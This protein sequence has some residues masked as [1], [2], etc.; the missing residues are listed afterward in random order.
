MPPV[1]ER[2][3]ARAGRLFLLPALGLFGVF[4]VLPMLGGL[5]LSF[6]DFDI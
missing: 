3:E 5:A 6:T 2:Q 4:F 1:I